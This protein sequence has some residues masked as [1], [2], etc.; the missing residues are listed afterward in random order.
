R[1]IPRHPSR[2]RLSGLSRSQR[3]A[4]PLPPPRR[5]L[6]RH[7]PDGELR[8]AARRLRQRP[9]FRPPRVAVLRRGEGGQGPSPR[10]PP[11][12]R[13]APPPRRALAS[14]RPRLRALMGVGAS[15]FSFSTTCR[16]SGRL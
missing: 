6:P 12:Q 1:E 10:L 4:D 14:P 5:A 13:P 3:E 9:L 8:H 7:P 16:R 11:A 15:V 2:A